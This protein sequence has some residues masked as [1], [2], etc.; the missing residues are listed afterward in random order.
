MVWRHL[1]DIAFSDAKQLLVGC[2]EKL[3]KKDSEFD[4]KVSHSFKTAKWKQTNIA[5]LKCKTMFLFEKIEKM[6]NLILCFLEI[7]KIFS[8][9]RVRQADFLCE[10][11]KKLS[12]WGRSHFAV[13]ALE[14]EVYRKQTGSNISVLLTKVSALEHDRFMQVS[15]HTVSW[16]FGNI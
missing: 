8:C 2:R 3:G 12:V 6:S 7:P 15:L 9:V 5:A 16:L 13:F 1:S 10:D 14:R 4:S 11:W